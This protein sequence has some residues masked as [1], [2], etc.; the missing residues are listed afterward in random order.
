MIG[1]RELWR[2]TCFR[3]RSAKEVEALKEEIRLH[4]ELRA[5]ALEQRGLSAEQAKYGARKRFGN[6]TLVEEASRDSWS[7][8]RIEA[9]WRDV[10]LASRTLRHNPSFT[11]TSLLTLTLVIGA[12]TAVFSIVDAT[13]LRPLPYPN[14]ERLGQAVLRYSVHGD[15]GFFDALDGKMWELLRD[16]AN[17][18]DAAVYS[19]MSAPV[20][21]VASGRVGYL[22]Q[23]RVSAGYFH[24]LGVTP[25]MGHEFSRHEDVDGGP[26]LAILSYAAWQSIFH[27]EP[28]VIGRSVSLR[29]QPYT[30]TAVMP[31]ELRTSVGAEVWTPLHPSTQGEGSDNNYDIMARLRPGVTWQQ[32][33]AQ[34]EALGALRLKEKHD[35]PTAYQVSV[36][37]VPLQQM[38]MY[39]LRIPLLLLWCAVAAVL[40]IGCANIAGLL[41]VRSA[42][43]TR[44]IAT[45]MALGGGRRQ[46]VR[47]LLME[48]LLLSVSGGVLGIALGSIGITLLQTLARESLG[49]WQT[50]ALDRRVLLVSCGVTLFATLLFGLLPALLSSRL[51][52]RAAL[53]DSGSKGVA[54]R[55]NHWPGRLLV[56]GEVALG[57]MLLIAAGLVVRSFLYLRNQPKGFEAN[58]V[59]AATVPLQDARYQSNQKVNRLFEDILSRSRNLPNVEAAAAAMS[60]PYERGL[61]TM[62][63]IRGQEGKDIVLTYVTPEYFRVLRVPVLRGRGFTG[64]DNS[65]APRVAVV[66]SLLAKT[67]FGVSDPIGREVVQNG[68]SV[69]IVGLVDDLPMKGSLEGYSPIAAMPLMFVPAA[70]I[71]D[72]LFQVINTWFAP[73]V[74]VR[75]SLPP[76]HMASIMQRTIASVDPLLR[77]SGFHGIDDIRSDTLARQQFQAVVMSLLAG[78]SLFLAAI[79]IYGLMSNT[80]VERTREIG[81]RMALGATARQ[82]IGAMAAHGLALAAVGIIVGFLV[83]L[84]AVPLL[85]H[86]IWG[87]KPTD[88][89]IFAGTSAVLLGVATAAILIPALRIV[90]LNPAETLRN[91]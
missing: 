88:P 7:L 43:R 60:L 32:A 85:R 11:L 4:L 37:L 14:A 89:A 78:L 28:G 22:R 57:L 1:L 26:P 54:G 29:G 75:T 67:F 31:P 47:Q 40:L 23:Q 72:G 69:Q 66:S 44:E 65:H 84:G 59:L 86:M 80:V 19:D 20:N 24:V 49:L 5:R 8:L 53:T 2:R 55:R 90:S 17:L 81:I 51:D 70:Q 16:H 61:N 27:G 13:L 12:N 83:S 21:F 74:V 39:D 36:A 41:I 64:S 58:N 48:S 38:A 15:Q 50:I 71:P 52:I 35:I 77:F 87:I 33:R 73:S 25:L 46:V 6:R 42:G 91:E 30:I 18:M 45:R 62:A 3:W 9:I 82:V 63:A 79:G 68:G 34:V 10:R 76:T 56:I